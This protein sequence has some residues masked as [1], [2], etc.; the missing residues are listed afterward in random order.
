MPS[1]QHERLVEMFR[2]RGELAPALLELCGVHQLPHDR[3]VPGSIDFSQSMP[4]EYRADAVIE[5]RGRDHRLTAAVVVEVQLRRDVTKRF[6]W[7]LYLA[8]LR[9]AHRCD[10]VL[11]VLTA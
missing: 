3:A 11:L 4:I 5:L 7:P 6:T 10:V 2:T 1:S 9:A 8:A